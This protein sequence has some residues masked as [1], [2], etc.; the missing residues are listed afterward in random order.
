ML[1]EY[2]DL[3]LEF[4]DLVSRVFAD[5]Y[6][7][8]ARAAAPGADDAMAQALLARLARD[9]PPGEDERRFAERIEFD[10]FGPACPFV[11]SAGSAANVEHTALARHLR[12]RGILAAS[13]GRRVSGVANRPVPWRDLAIPDDAAYAEAGPVLPGRLSA[14]LDE[15]R[16]VVEVATRHHHRGPV[17][18]HQY[19]AE[20]ILWRS[21]GLAQQIEDQVYG[22]L[23]PELSHTLDALIEHNFD[24]AA[25]AAS[26]PV[27]RN[28]LTN[29]MI[30]IRETSGIDIEDVDGRGLVWL[31]WLTRSAR[32]QRPD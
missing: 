14:T 23:D 1:A 7:K 25:A 5:E 24:R 27:H 10:V 28:T 21:P 19:R 2:A 13:R 9:E 30:R 29:R 6:A 26:L 22:P 16:A 17:G 3:L 18:P 31:A 8:A 20:A 12:G 11:M 4:V 32:A 15:L